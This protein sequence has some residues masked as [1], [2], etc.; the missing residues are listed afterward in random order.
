[1]NRLSPWFA[2]PYYSTQEQALKEK[3]RIHVKKKQEW[4]FCFLVTTPYDCECG[5]EF[6]RSQPQKSAFPTP[7]PA[8][9]LGMHSE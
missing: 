9:S 2:Q 8:T 6:G 1:M 3:E 5:L 4:A 7:P